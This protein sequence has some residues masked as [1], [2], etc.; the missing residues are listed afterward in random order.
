MD[1]K[2]APQK[3][4][5]YL[6][7]LY[8]DSY[9]ISEKARL[10]VS[11]TCRIYDYV[12]ILIL[13]MI[14]IFPIGLINKRSVQYSKNSTEATVITINTE[15]LL[16]IYSNDN[17]AFTEVLLELQRNHYSR[18]LILSKKE[19]PYEIQQKSSLFDKQ[20]IYYLIDNTLLENEI[21]IIV[22]E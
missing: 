11:Y 12:Q 15:K 16:S 8:Y 21:K 20:K 18:I 1:L 9:F 10:F 5:F 2:T 14:L 22:E 19:V 13:I 4:K 3:E 6:E 17:I 7:Q